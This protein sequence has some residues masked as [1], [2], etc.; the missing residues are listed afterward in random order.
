M[1]KRSPKNFWSIGVDIEEI[2]RFKKFSRRS[3]SFLKSIFTTRELNY[4]FSQALPSRHLAARFAA[5]EAVIKAVAYFSLPLGMREIEVRRSGSSIPE[6]KI[7]KKINSK[8][9]L[10]IS[11]AHSPKFAIAFAFVAKT[12]LL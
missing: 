4:C 6:I 11:L 1:L 2:G 8:M 9:I 10:K 3:D 5:K 7:H 12:Q